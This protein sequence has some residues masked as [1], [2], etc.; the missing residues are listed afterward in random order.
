MQ[1]LYQAVR[2]GDR[3][4][5]KALVY[6]DPTLAIFAAAMSGDI[7]EMSQLLAANPSLVTAVSPDGWYPL[8][9]AAHFA[10]TQAVR[11]LLHHGAQ[12]GA[13][14]T[15]ALKNTAL[16]AAAAGRA[17][18]AAKILIEH[19]ASASATQHGGWVSLHA[20]AQNGACSSTPAPM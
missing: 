13:R 19:G 16:H 7:E 15:N 6:A 5:V 14:S 3:E 10:Q 11:L 2:A 1:E 12:A 20:A 18:E 4:K 9:L 17:L 8:H